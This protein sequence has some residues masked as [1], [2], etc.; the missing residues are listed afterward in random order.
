MKTI[1][2]PTDFSPEAKN[3]LQL[4]IGLG[5]QFGSTLIVLHV[6]ESVDEGSFNVE[7]ES[8]GSGDWEDRLFN[9][10]MIQKAKKDLAKVEDDLTAAG[11]KFKTMLRLGD[12]YHGMNTVITEQKTDLVVMGTRGSSGYEEVLIGTNTEKVVRRSG[13][14]VIAVTKKA[15]ID[16]KN[17]AWATSLRAEDLVMPSA[18]KKIIEAYQATVHLVRINTPGL[19][20]PDKT[21]QTKLKEFATKLKLPRYTINIYNE[22]SE[23]EGIIRFADSV[24]ADM[25]VMSTHGRTGLGHL[26]NGSIAEDVVNHAKRPVFTFSLKAK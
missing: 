24:D 25:I 8:S 13:C 15:F 6:L 14:P 17:I 26:L 18:L 1:L 10:R 5:R 22:V 4:A 23:E 9:M 12:A 21:S 2:V 20:L 19:F 11:V 7:G 16:F 3:A